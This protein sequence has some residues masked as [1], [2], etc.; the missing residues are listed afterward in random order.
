MP[1]V[2]DPCPDLAGASG[3]ACIEFVTCPNT[4]WWD[5]CLFGGCDEMFTVIDRLINPV[6][7]EVETVEIVN[8]SL[9]LFPN[10]GMS[11]QELADVLGGRSG[12]FGAGAA[13]PEGRIRIELWRRTQD[14]AEEF[15]AV[16]AEYLPSDVEPGGV[17]EG[18]AL[19]ISPTNLGDPS[20]TSLRMDQVYA[21]GADADTELP[22]ED[23]D[24]APNPFDNCL[25]LFNPEQVDSDG[26]GY[27]NRCDADY[28]GGG[29]VGIPDFNR[30]RSAFGARCGTPAYDPAVD[31]DGNCAIG[32]SDFR[33]LRLQFGDAPGPSGRACTPLTCP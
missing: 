33:L 25:G 19:K 24:R 28:D 9:Y 7:L 18:V 23:K 27:G 12:P 5:V 26:D 30:L 13:V 31:A 15:I 2:D 8:Q 4:V 14:G 20:A 16:I 17:P 3:L 10:A 6:P 29:R 32:L 1:D 21:A 22:D 11:V